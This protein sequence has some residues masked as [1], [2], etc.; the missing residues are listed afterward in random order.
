[1]LISASSGLA[2]DP[3]APTVKFEQDRL[4]VRVDAMPLKEVLDRVA[5]A[6]GATIRGS[7]PDRTVTVSVTAAPLSEGLETILGSHS[8]ILKYGSG[9]AP[10]AVE[11]L[12]AGEPVALV[13]AATPG[14]AAV[15]GVAATPGPLEAEEAQAKILQR[16]VRVSGDLAAAV[17]S[18]QPAIGRLLHAVVREPDAGV[19]AAARDALIAALSGDPEAEAAYLSTLTP[20]ENEVLANMLQKSSAEDGAA[21]WMA[22]LAARAP[23]EALRAKAAAVLALLPH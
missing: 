5:K 11:L 23:S 4:T 3:G 14:V 10:R 19:R 15:P 8:F 13:P 21:A 7:V 22:Y 17:G 16:T 2:D 18:E 6:T 12:G 9:G 20:V 1:V